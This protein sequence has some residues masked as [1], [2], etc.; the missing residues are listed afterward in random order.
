MK[1][2]ITLVEIEQELISSDWS[3]LE[4]S[5]K[6][7]TAN[8]FGGSFAFGEGLNENQTFHYYLSMF[9][10][11]LDIKNYSFHGYGMHN[12]L[13]LLENRISRNSQ[14]NIFFTSAFHSERSGCVPKYTEDHPTYAEINTQGGRK[15]KFIGYCKGR[16]HEPSFLDRLYEK[17]SRNSSLVK[18][19]SRDLIV[20]FNAEHLAL[21]QHI[22]ND[23][24][25]ISKDQGAIPIFMYL[26]EKSTRFLKTGLR[27]DPMPQF[28]AR[29]D[30]NSFDATLGV[31][32]ST[33]DRHL[34]LHRHDRHPSA[35]ANCFRAERLAVYL[36]RNQSHRPAIFQLRISMPAT[37]TRLAS[38]FA[39]GA[40][41]FCPSVRPHVRQAAARG[42][43]T[44]FD[45]RRVLQPVIGI[46][47]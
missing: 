26:K 35:L 39:I 12:A 44:S 3:R 7:I 10:P 22:I 43:T 4:K 9:V 45:S 13:F 20:G 24:D 37:L 15:T 47:A 8:I 16:M 18:Y 42:M 31:D 40:R 17:L 2:N 25:L 33:L 46:D 5:S 21:Y 38:G 29:H 28:F 27:S 1:L 32:R 41:Q 14:I 6:P 23:L 30:I 34:Y 19:T 36:K 11:V